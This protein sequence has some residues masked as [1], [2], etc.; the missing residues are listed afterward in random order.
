MSR[1][2]DLLWGDD[3]E[4]VCTGFPSSPPRNDDEDEWDVE[5]ASTVA[6]PPSPLPEYDGPCIDDVRLDLALW[7][8]ECKANHRGGCSEYIIERTK[9]EFGVQMVARGGRVSPWEFSR[10]LEMVVLNFELSVVSAFDGTGI[11]GDDFGMPADEDVFLKGEKRV[12]AMAPDGTLAWTLC[13][14]ILSK[15]HSVPGTARMGFRICVRCTDP[16]FEKRLFAHTRPFRVLS[17]SGSR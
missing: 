4:E 12:Q 6:C 8:N 16:R 13:P 14:T 17:R 10:K 15:H 7:V 1:D 11:G 5:T 9:T 3:D 2:Y